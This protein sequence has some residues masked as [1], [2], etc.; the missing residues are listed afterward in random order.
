MQRCWPGHSARLDRVRKATTEQSHQNA[1]GSCR[2]SA[3][4]QATDEPRQRDYS[5]SCHAAGQPGRP[6]MHKSVNTPLELTWP[7][8]NGQQLHC[9]E[10]CISHATV[11]A[12]LITNRIKLLP[13][14]ELQGDCAAGVLHLFSLFHAREIMQEWSS[15]PIKMPPSTSLHHLGTCVV[16]RVLAFLCVVDTLPSQ[17]VHRHTITSSTSSARHRQVYARR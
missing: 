5:C 1:R 10:N 16:V 15:N 12:R 8:K 4:T 11:Y 3:G 2:A 7:E 13:S 9:Q 6:T 17:A 14:S